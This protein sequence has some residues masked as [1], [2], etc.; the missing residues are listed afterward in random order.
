M[1][2]LASLFTK[3]SI[4]QAANTDLSFRYYRDTY[5]YRDIFITIDCHVK[6]LLS[7]TSSSGT[8]MYGHLK[9]FVGSP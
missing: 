3:F 6:I 8:I 1:Y 9:D 2:K 4:V 5:R 7:P